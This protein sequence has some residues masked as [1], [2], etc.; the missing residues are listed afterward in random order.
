MKAPRSRRDIVVLLGFLVAALVLAGVVSYYASTSPDGL[1]KVAIDKRFAGAEEPH[2]LENSP[3]AGYSTSDVDNERLSGGLAGVA[4]VGATLVLAGG[5][6]M[7]V[8][9]RSPPDETDHGAAGPVP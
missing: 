1:N 2:D 3:L 5:L 8:R 7:L 4:G 9:R 6:A